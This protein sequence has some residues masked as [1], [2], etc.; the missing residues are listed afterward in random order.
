MNFA[1]VPKPWDAR[2]ELEF[3]SMVLYP[4]EPQRRQTVL[5]RRRHDGPLRVQKS[6]YP[7]GER[8]CH[9]VILHPPA[10]IAGG[11][12]LDLDVK[13]RADGHATI[14]TPSAAKWYKSNGGVARQSTRIELGANARLDWLPQENLVFDQA[15]A[16][17]RFTLE[18]DP[19]AAAIG[20]D[21]TMLGRTARGERFDHGELGLYTHISCGAKS[22][23]REQGRLRGGDALLS[24]PVGLA[25]MPVM[26]TL[27]A[28]GAACTTALG[29]TLAPML[30]WS[31]QLRAGSTVLPGGL[32]LVRILGVEIEPVR[33]VLESVWTRLRPTVL[34]TQAQP[35]RL[36]AS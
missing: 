28:L 21:A 24:S 9:T 10:G 12:V 3:T 34:G 23:W 4:H 8:V 17:T 33:S 20:W 27:W 7:E 31:A 22:L 32:L 18:A 29:Q 26:A 1:V 13:V 35:L 11:D 19:S 2:L 36:W 6:L 16:E 14:S 25:G 15:R 30:P 5:S